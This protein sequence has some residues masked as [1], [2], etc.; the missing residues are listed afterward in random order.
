MNM[1]IKVYAFILLALPSATWCMDGE[2]AREQKHAYNL[3]MKLITAACLA[4]SSKRTAMEN[5]PRAYVAFMDNQPTG[6]PEIDTLVY[7]C[8]HAHLQVYRAAESQSQKTFGTTTALTPRQQ[9][10]LQNFAR[11]LGI[12][13][14]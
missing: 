11:A 12:T 1:N 2:P 7:E 8:V 13:T 14:E 3:E 6:R 5:N 4:Y 9:G 10:V